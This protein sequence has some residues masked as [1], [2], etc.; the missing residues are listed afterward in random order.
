MT[1]ITNY[2]GKDYIIIAGDKRVTRVDEVKKMN[3]LEDRAV[4][5]FTGGK[6]CIGIQ[7]DVK[8]E[9][10]NYHNRLAL[11]IKKSHD[12]IPPELINMLLNEFSD[13]HEDK[14]VYELN[15]IISGTNGNELFSYFIDAKNQAVLNCGCTLPPKRNQ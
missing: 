3:I 14:E 2:I 6:Y 10:S 8:T 13:V 15:L 1:L 4:K 5:I 9:K 7:G 12:L 11:F